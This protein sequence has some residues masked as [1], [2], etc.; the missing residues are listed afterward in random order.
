[1]H[2]P[3]IDCKPKIPEDKFELELVSAAVSAFKLH[4]VVMSDKKWKNP[5]LVA[6]GCQEAINQEEFTCHITKI[7]TGQ[8]DE[9]VLHC[10]EYLLLYPS[11]SLPSDSQIRTVFTQI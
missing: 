2:R 3:T 7:G 11:R 9:D 8:V 6:R 1:V 10:V 5:D 4:G